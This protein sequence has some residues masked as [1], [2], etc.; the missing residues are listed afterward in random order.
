MGVGMERNLER[1]TGRVAVV[2][3]E[4]KGEAKRGTEKR[5]IANNLLHVPITFF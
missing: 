4:S 1:K 2:G 5:R 3:K